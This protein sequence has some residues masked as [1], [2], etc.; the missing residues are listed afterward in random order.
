MQNI[1]AI[2][3]TIQRQSVRL[4]IVTTDVNLSGPV[5]PGTIKLLISAF[6]FVVKKPACA[7]WLLDA[8]FSKLIIWSIYKIKQN[9]IIQ[10]YTNGGKILS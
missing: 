8:F 5:P 10:Y 3:T 4:V 1:N 2:K 6:L 9:F 7:T